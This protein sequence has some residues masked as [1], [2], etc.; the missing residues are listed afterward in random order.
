M[1]AFTDPMLT[2]D[3]PPRAFI[4]AM[5][6]CRHTNGARRLMFIDPIPELDGCVLERRARRRGRVVHQ[7]VDPA[8]LLDR[9]SHDVT[10]GFDIDE[11]AANRRHS[12]ALVSERPR[13]LARLRLVRPMH[14]HAGAQRGEALGN[15]ASDA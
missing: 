7:H 12:E 6:S 10:A 1:Y 13:H 3:P 11:I 8:E 4:D 14:D 5:A 15:A 2:T 9:E